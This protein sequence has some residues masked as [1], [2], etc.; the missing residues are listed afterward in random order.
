M[1][2]IVNYTSK[3]IGVLVGFVDMGGGLSMVCANVP[4]FGVGICRFGNKL[5]WTW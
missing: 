1:A 3:F 2:F 5:P 4:W